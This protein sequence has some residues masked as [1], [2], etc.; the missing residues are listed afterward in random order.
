VSHFSIIVYRAVLGVVDGVKPAALLVVDGGDAGAQ[1]VDQL[2]GAS[3]DGVEDGGDDD[4]HG[5]LLRL[6]E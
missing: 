1:R 2:G 6:G 4:G 5:S 3:V